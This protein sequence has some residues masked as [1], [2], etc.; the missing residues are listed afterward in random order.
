MNKSILCLCAA[1]VVSLMAI[2]S[3]T[4]SANDNVVFANDPEPY[5][6]D[7]T[8]LSPSN[9]VIT[10]SNGNNINFNVLGYDNGHLNYDGSFLIQ[11]TTPISGLKS[12]SFS[13]LSDARL[14][15]SYGWEFDDYAGSGAVITDEH[16]SFDFYDES[17]SFIKIESFS[18]EQWSVG[19][20]LTYSCNA[21]MLPDDYLVN[22]SFDW[23]TN[24][25]VINGYREGLVHADIPST[26]HGYPVSGMESGAF[27]SCTTLESVS[28]PN[29]ITS[30]SYMA[31]SQCTSLSSV[32][33]PDGLLEIG[34]YAFYDCTFTSIDIPDSVVTIRDNA[35]DSVP[36]S[37]ISLP[38]GLTSIS[39][40][41]LYNTEITS[42]SI[43]SGVTS[44]GDGAFI[45]CYSL[46]RVDDIPDGLV[47]IGNSA[48]SN[49]GALSSFDLP[50]S[51]RSIGNWAFSSTGIESIDIPVGV[52]S[53]SNYCFMRC[54]S[55]SS[56]SLPAGITSIGDYA[57]QVCD[58]L[59][60]IVLPDGLM[61]IG[62]F[63]FNGCRLF[64]SI[65]IPDEV[66]SIGNY[67]FA[68]NEN[69]KT[70]YYEGTTD[71]WSNISF[72]NGWVN[73]TPLESIVCSDGT[74]TL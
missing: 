29:G 6:L 25:Y 14:A 2:A 42:I 66:T 55:L 67:A 61:S 40:Y 71:Q 50:A 43:P 35:F 34:S 16:P 52:T 47:N 69:L 70:I 31:F 38:S 28:L 37:S 13:N 23:G 74:I 56:V 26:L 17:P 45:N 51:V 1:S 4:V 20:T 60:S 68:Y 7:I 48:F 15:I 59:P 18:G 24:S 30:V 9:H 73:D 11:N 3:V 5:V 10:T 8:S 27:A 41:L 44:I 54:R 39:N 62:Q 53:I 58:A 36:L 12:I 57:F 33:L 32:D 65:N 19:I 46:E 63:A 49:C 64:T 21:S 72:G 22:Y